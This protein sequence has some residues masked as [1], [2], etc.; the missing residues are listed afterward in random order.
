MEVDSMMQRYMWN[1][2]WRHAHIGFNGGR[3]VP[4]DVRA[5]DEAYVITAELPGMKR[6]EIKIDILDDVVTLRGE[7]AVEEDG[8]TVALWRE[9]PELSKFSRRLRLPD[10]V[11]AEQAEATLENGLLTLRIPKAETARPKAIEIKP[12]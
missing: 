10:A 3:R 11:D 7:A 1:P 5:D 9:I 12:K 2:G 4:L 6:D 8:Q